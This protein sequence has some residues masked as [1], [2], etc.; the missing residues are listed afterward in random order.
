MPYSEEDICK[1]YDNIST[2]D[3]FAIDAVSEVLRS[4]NHKAASF[5]AIMRQARSQ[6]ACDT[7][8]P[9][10]MLIEVLTFAEADY[11]LTVETIVELHHQKHYASINVGFYE[12]GERQLI[13]YESAQAEGTLDEHPRRLVKRAFEQIADRMLEQVAPSSNP[14]P[15]NAPQVSLVADIARNLPQ[16]TMQNPDAVAVVIGNAQYEKTKAVSFALND[17][18]LMK[19][20]LM[21]VLGFREENIFHLQNATKSD[22]EL[23]F[24][25][26]N[27]PRGRLYNSVKPNKSDVFVF[28]SGHGAPG[29]RDK[30]AYFVPTDCDPQ[31]LE[32]GGYSSELLYQNLAQIPARNTT[33][34][35]DACFSGVDIFENISPIVIKAKGIRGVPNGVLIASSAE[36]EVSSWHN[37]QKQGL[38]TYFLLKA[39]HNRNADQNGDAKLSFREVYDFISDPSE[40]IPFYARR[41]H[42]VKQTPLVQGDNLDDIWITYQ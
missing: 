23:Y 13:S 14:A 19:L 20:Y 3:R 5:N 27:N 33:V 42:G 39:V 9:D 35:I 24:G 10:K 25:I 22:F 4:L 29:L 18:A 37:E 34:V 8:N 38:L 28:Y 36:D 6:G 40:G 2:E 17:A 21:K 12:S 32:L 41:L 16:S 31:Y 30:N 7:H 26:R 1:A 15:P 11:Y